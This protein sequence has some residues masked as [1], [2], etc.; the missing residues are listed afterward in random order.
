MSEH[1]R[2]AC[3]GAADAAAPRA[4]KRERIG[5][6]RDGTLT[7][8]RLGAEE[9]LALDGLLT[10]RKPILAGQTRRIPL[11]Q[12]EAALRAGGIEPRL[13]YERVGG[14]PL[15]DLPAE[16]AAARLTQ[17]QFRAWLSEHSVATQRP[18]VAAWLEAAAR[19]GQ[20]HAGM[21][22]AIERALRIVAALPSA[23]PIQRTVLAARMLD[24]DPHGLDVDTPLHRL[25]VALLAA[26]AGLDR[27]TPARTVWGASNVLVDPVSSNVA[28]LNLPPLPPD[29]D[30]GKLPPTIQGT[31]MVLTYG[32]LSANV[33]R[34]APGATCFS[35]ENPSV[36]IAA[37]Q[38]L[39]TD[40]PPLV[41]TGGRPSDA[42]Q[43]SSPQCATR[44]ARFVITAITTA[45]GCRSSATSRRGT[46]PRRGDSTDRR[47]ARRCAASAG[48]LPIR[49]RR[50]SR[51]L[52]ARWTA[53]SPRNS[54]STNCLTTYAPR[55]VTR[56]RKISVTTQCD[57]WGGVRVLVRH[58]DRAGDRR[59][60]LNRLSCRLMSSR[61]AHRTAHLS[62]VHAQQRV[63]STQGRSGQ[64]SGTNPRWSEPWQTKSPACPGF[65]GVS[66]GGGIR[67]R[68]LRVMSPTSYQ[69]APPRGGRTMIA[70]LRR[71]WGWV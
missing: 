38:A 21:R 15:R 61:L 55:S 18:A 24:A 68:D 69:T 49:R 26:A 48:S 11:S 17:S 64:E 29:V 16:R 65:H 12:L 3:A 47:C 57:G 25:T 30:A 62:P 7:L 52:S 59:V 14:R 36:L 37:E 28:V 67:T 44:A 9:A 70:E 43:L 54:S 34:W 66:S 50:R 51:M 5:A 45:P 2:D 39:G 19:Q 10:P 60:H 56:D 6:G 4:D 42:V 23:E 33:L 20:V 32:Q 1:G 71:T 35:C 13:A 40:C 8:T 58:C 63:A 46:A 41:C 22:P 53:D 31:H 27:D